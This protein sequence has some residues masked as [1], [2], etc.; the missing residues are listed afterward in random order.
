MWTD[1]PIERVFANYDESGEVT[2]LTCWIN[3]RG[4]MP[5]AS[6]DALFDLAASELHQIRGA[7]IRGARVVRWDARQ[8]FAGGA[9]MHWASGQIRRW[10]ER[11]GQSAGRIHFAGEQL[12]YMHTGME[13]AME[14]GE[15]TAFSVM[16][17]MAER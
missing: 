14:S 16:Q 8:P 4:V 10:A 5:D 2:S 3:G 6:D 15:W 9:Y 7:K 17:E 13:G 12:S 1:S 11:M